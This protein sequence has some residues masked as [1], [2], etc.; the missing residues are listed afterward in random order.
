M[1]QRK[2]V[3]CIEEL[4]ERADVL[5]CAAACL[6]NLLDEPA[7]P[8]HVKLS[9]AKPAAK[10]RPAAPARRRPH[11]AGK[12]VSTTQ[13]FAVVAGATGLTHDD[14]AAKLGKRDVRYQL[15]KLQAAGRVTLG[16]DK[17]YRKT[18]SPSAAVN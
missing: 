5:L 17:K 14:I 6:E 1:N 8:P 7:P 2:V 12:H 4:R 3:E 16:G 13:V 10:P 11:G 18:V 9:A 15:K